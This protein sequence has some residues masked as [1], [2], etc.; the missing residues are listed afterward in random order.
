MKNPL[1]TLLVILA[2]SLCGLCTWQWYGQVLQRRDM[3]EMG[4][5]IHDQATA[6]RGYTNSISTMDRQIAQLDASVTELRD[7]TRSNAVT[8]AALQRESNTFSNQAVRYREVA[9]ENAKQANET[10][11]HQNETIKSLIS[12]RDGFVKQLNDSIKERNEVVTQ[13]N[14]LVKRVNEERAAS[15]NKAGA[16]K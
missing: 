15:T 14:E 7:V 8:I 16:K 6:I 11:R 3:T 2:L 4:Q 10:I 12:E 1:Q 9:E 5:K 13:F